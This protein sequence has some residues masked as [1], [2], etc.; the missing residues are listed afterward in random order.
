M[1]QAPRPLISSTGAINVPMQQATMPNYGANGHLV[2]PGLPQ[3]MN[4]PFK[5]FMQTP[6]TFLPDP[7]S[8][9][10][11]I[12]SMGIQT[13]GHFSSIG[14]SSAG[15]PAFS[16]VHGFP[17][18]AASPVAAS[19]PQAVPAYSSYAHASGKVFNHVEV[20][21]PPPMASGVFT[22][23]AGVSQ[24][25]PTAAVPADQVSFG[26][27]SPVAPAENV[28]VLIPQVPTQTVATS[29]MSAGSPEAQ[30]SLLNSSVQASSIS[31]QGP[32]IQ[33]GP[34]MAAGSGSFVSVGLPAPPVGSI[35]Q[36]AVAA[37]PC[38]GSMS[39]SLMA[40]VPQSSGRAEQ[41][42][43]PSGQSATTVPNAAEERPSSPPA[44]SKK[45][46]EAKSGKAKKKE[47]K[48]CLCF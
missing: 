16:S 43:S 8:P 29:V 45:E 13:S 46:G 19:L 26:G 4:G 24:M 28:A 40:T 35:A 21:A 34:A 25:P 47:T 6:T 37:V 12:H 42:P 1:L 44:A 39:P 5:F 10:G 48:R 15:S 11:G 33:Y 36:P 32:P 38:A 18:P 7:A 17:A 22:S 31:L 2:S 9:Q 41:A 20:P 23:L 30:T 14:A 3:A 27:A